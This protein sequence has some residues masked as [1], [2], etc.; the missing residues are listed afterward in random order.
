MLLYDLNRDYQINCAKCRVPDAA[1]N[2]LC[3]KCMNPEHGTRNFFLAYKS[4]IFLK[5]YLTG[6]FSISPYKSNASASVI[7]VV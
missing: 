7:L 4:T 1:I 3:C 2:Y 5:L 6:I